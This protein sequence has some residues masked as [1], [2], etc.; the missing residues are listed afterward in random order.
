MRCTTT[1]LYFLDNVIDNHQHVKAALL[2]TKVIPE[3][4]KYLFARFPQPTYK[5]LHAVVST[6]FKFMWR[7]TLSI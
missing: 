1:L 7:S 4:F 2:K 3:K 5:Y 6:L